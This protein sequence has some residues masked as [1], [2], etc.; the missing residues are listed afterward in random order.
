V[1]HG[2]AGD[3]GIIH[4]DGDRAERLFDLG[5][6]SADRFKVTDIGLNAKNA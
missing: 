1:Q 5:K 3:P 2:I 6:G 4:Q